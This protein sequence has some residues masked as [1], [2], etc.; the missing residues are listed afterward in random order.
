MEVDEKVEIILMLQQGKLIQPLPKDGSVAPLSNWRI[1]AELFYNRM[2]F[3][4]LR[5]MF[6]PPCYLLLFVCVG[7]W[8]A[9]CL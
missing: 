1:Q 7:M 9:M 8:Q 6:A 5:F 4:Q 2:P 3:T